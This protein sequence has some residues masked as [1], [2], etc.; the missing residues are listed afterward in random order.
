MNAKFG[1]MLDFSELGHIG[2]IPNYG[3]RIV[4][5]LT[6]AI[7]LV[8]IS[9]NSIAEDGKPNYADPLKTLPPILAK[10]VTLPDDKSPVLCPVQKDFS[11][12]LQLAEAIDIT[13]CNNPQLRMSW[14]NIK[15]QAGQL[16]EARAAYLP[17]L[18]ATATDQRMRTNYPGSA[19]LPDTRQI[20]ESYSGNFNLRLFDFGG[21][22]AN[23]NSANSLLLAS[24]ASHSA[25]IQKALTDT[26]Q[27]YFDAQTAKATWQA[28]QESEELSRQ[29]V[30]NAT[31]KSERGAAAHS[32]VLQA[33]AALA[34]ASLDT[35]RALGDYRKAIA[36]LVYTLGVSSQTTVQLAEDNHDQVKLESRNLDEWLTI[37]AESHPAIVAARAKWESSRQKI[38]STRSEGLP[39]LDFFY[40]YYQNGYPNQGL[41]QVSSHEYTYGITLNIPIFDGFARNYKIREAEATAEQDE[42]QLH[43]VEHNIMNEIVKANADALSSLENLAAGDALMEA[44]KDSVESSTRRYEKGAADIVELLNTQATLADANLQKIRCLSE[45]RSA[46]LRLLSN[47]GRM[48]H[49]IFH[50]D[51][52]SSRQSTIP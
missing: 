31:R 38:V 32:D 2:R 51:A 12:P 8:S 20:G 52:A 21:R 27:N 34:K 24:I 14:A 37:A 13:L 25:T 42:A 26:I 17:T 39:S 43:D 49:E 45:W 15:F 16:G 7:A 6:V 44:A 40:N 29:T 33:N 4:S 48:G 5:M 1:P 30:A 23:L 19:F 18:N 46:R 50:Q 36:N 10:G 3:R 28:K 35:N 22:G 9:N 47:A 11:Q 41:S